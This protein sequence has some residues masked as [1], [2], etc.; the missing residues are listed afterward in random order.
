MVSQALADITRHPCVPNDHYS[1]AYHLADHLSI[2]C[3][4]ITPSPTSQLLSSH[5]TTLTSVSL[6]MNAT[7]ITGTTASRRKSQIIKILKVLTLVDCL[8]VLSMHTTFF[9]GIF[10]SSPV[11]G[12]LP[13][14]AFLLSR[15]SLPIPGIVNCLF[16]L[17]S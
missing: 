3:I 15:T 6:H 8:E 10:I 12:F 4:Y 5:L 14:L 17:A 7:M 1:F 11:A 13:I 16:F 2:A 9:A